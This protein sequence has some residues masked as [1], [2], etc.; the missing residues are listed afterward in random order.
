MFK[1][2][3]LNKNYLSSFFIICAMLTF[4]KASYSQPFNTLIDKILLQDESI[5]TSKSLIKKIKMIYPQLD[6]CTHLN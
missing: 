6:L 1:L 2:Y 3:C 5:N 4:N